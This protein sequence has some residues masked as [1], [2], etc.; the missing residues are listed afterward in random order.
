MYI[1]VCEFEIREKR[2]QKRG[3]MQIPD[4]HS[5]VLIDEY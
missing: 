1:S 5:M 2:N 4:Q 3:K